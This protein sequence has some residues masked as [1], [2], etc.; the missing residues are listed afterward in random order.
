MPMPRSRACPAHRGRGAAGRRAWGVPPPGSALLAA[1]CCLAGLGR[2]GAA[3]ATAPIAS[4]QVIEGRVAGSW[5]ASAN[6][7]VFSMDGPT[8]KAA[9]YW[10]A[11]KLHVRLD[12][13]AGLP[14][15]RVSVYGCPSEGHPV[16][17]EFQNMLMR[18][19]LRATGRRVPPEWEWPGDLETLSFDATHKTFY[20]EVSQYLRPV[21]TP[22]DHIDLERR[23]R[24]AGWPAEADDVKR[25]G[26]R[27]AATGEVVSGDNSTAASQY[28]LKLL[29]E[30][31]YKVSVILYDEAR[32]PKDKL[33]PMTN[34]FGFE[35][36]ITLMPHP[37]KQLQFADDPVAA[38]YKI[39][40]WPPTNS[41]NDSM[42]ADPSTVSVNTSTNLSGLRRDDPSRRLLTQL[43]DRSAGDIGPEAAGGAGVHGAGTATR[44]VTANPAA[45][46]MGA[47]GE[48]A[49]SEM[50]R[51]E[52]QLERQRMIE[53]QLLA[54]QRSPSF[55][56]LLGE[57]DTAV[58]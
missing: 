51:L 29:P 44:S 20:I 57:G 14:H 54:T 25:I 46:G 23:L 16:N 36:D 56:S 18:N 1:A 4:E 32:V 52:A 40:F 37:A 33:M 55:V 5:P 24:S 58:P 31:A 47:G 22:G 30:S 21:R 15:M 27:L 6:C 39:A 7:Y 42:V 38:H 35:R 50:R 48:S 8:T 53:Q 41:K 43:D 9:V 19:D 3:V 12:P 11:P 2:A 26:D 17:W 45:A 49:R 13:C 28:Q 34:R 10:G